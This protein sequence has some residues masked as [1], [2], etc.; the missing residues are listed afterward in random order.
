MW[1]DVAHRAHAGQSVNACAARKPHQDRFR[2]IVAR[3]GEQ[4][5]PYVTAPAVDQ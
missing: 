3:M 2:L 4:D 5:M 1:S